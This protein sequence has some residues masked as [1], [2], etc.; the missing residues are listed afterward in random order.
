MGSDGYLVVRNR[1]TL[2]TKHVWHGSAR[3]IVS[4]SRLAVLDASKRVVNAAFVF[5][6]AR[7][8]EEHG[9]ET[10]ESNYRASHGIQQ[11]HKAEKLGEKTVNL[12]SFDEAV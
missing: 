7:T 12:G 11:R 4:G 1:L 9:A 10:W 2:S 3:G 8:S 6:C 5:R